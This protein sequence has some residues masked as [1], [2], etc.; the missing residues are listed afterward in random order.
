VGKEADCSV[1]TGSKR[2]AAKAHLDGER[3]RVRG[4]IRLDVPLADLRR[5]L[6]RD[7]ALVFEVAGET[8]ALELGP[9][10]AVAWERAIAQPK[11]LLE[12]LGVKPDQ[13]VCILG[14][15]RAFA[16]DV[17]AIAH[18]A[19]SSAL[20]G[21]FD[22]IFCAIESE[23]EL[24][25]IARCKEHLVANGAL[26]AVAPKGKGSPV[27]E[28]V[29]RAAL[30]D[31]GLVDTKVASFSATHTALKAVIPVDERPRVRAT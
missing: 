23:A 18:R 3:L 16:D 9:K 22:M 29:L 11:S 2:G 30:L 28:N 7:G 1:V 21:N 25:R 19:P 4:A 8:V 14:L 15:G 20:R 12:K 6:V 10:A 31:A 5:V 17:A 13:R 24:V 27:R 26:W